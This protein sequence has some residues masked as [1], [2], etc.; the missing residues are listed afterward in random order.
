MSYARDLSS[1][2]A[3][4]LLEERGD[5]ALEPQVQRCVDA[6]HIDPKLESVGGSRPAQIV[7]EEPCFDIATLLR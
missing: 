5:R 1:A 6:P 4:S 2:G 7:P 3:A